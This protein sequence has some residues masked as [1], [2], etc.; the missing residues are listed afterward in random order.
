[1]NDHFKYLCDKTGISPVYGLSQFGNIVTW[2]YDAPSIFARG[3]HGALENKNIFYA[4]DFLAGLVK[5][6]EDLEKYKPLYL[7]FN[8][9]WHDIYDPPSKNIRV[10]DG[11]NLSPRE[12]ISALNWNRSQRRKLQE[13]I[14]KIKEIIESPK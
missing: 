4:V 8:E 9:F 2:L 12:M 10:R 13:K 7:L 6:G 1:M 14:N 3:S 5:S 11:E